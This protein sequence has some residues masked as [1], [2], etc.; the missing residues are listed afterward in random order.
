MTKRRY[1][2]VIPAAGSVAR[3]HAPVPKQY[4][5][6]AGKTLIEHALERLGNHP[7]ISG[8]VVAISAQDQWWQEVRP[9][10]R[11]PVMQVTGGSQRCHSVLAGLACL[12]DTAR[13]ED[14]VLVHDAARPCLPHR[15]L[16]LLITEL[17]DHP[18]GGLL[19]LPVR[20]TM[21]RDNGERTVTATVERAGLWHALTPQMFRYGALREALEAAI[22]R[23]RIVTDE[24]QA[25]EL[26]GAQPRL[27]EG[28]AENIKITRP[29]DLALAEFYL[30]LQQEMP[31]CA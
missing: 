21:K 3:M 8:V 28:S 7:W 5:M 30:C 2:A 17:S 31:R 29:Q 26:T 23:D 13:S 15:D 9:S 20:D 19:A 6:L 4:L 24:A 10:C 25:M 14:W 27:V 11:A 1:W 22:A 16:D 18:V 12:H